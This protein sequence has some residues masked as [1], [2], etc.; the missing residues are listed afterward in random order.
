MTYYCFSSH[1][2]NSFKLNFIEIGI[3]S[4][5]ILN[6]FDISDFYHPIKISVY[7]LNQ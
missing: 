7:V 6:I 4:I 5:G 1:K 3:K 2:F